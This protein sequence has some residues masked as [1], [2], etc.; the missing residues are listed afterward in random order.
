MKTQKDFQTLYLEYKF[1]ASAQSV[2]DAWISKFIAELWF[3]K[4]DTNKLYFTAEVKE[5]GNFSVVE[6]DGDKII[7]HWGKYLEIDRPR[8]LHFTL[9]V[10]AHFEGVSDVVVEIKA[11]PYGCKLFFTQKNIDTSKTKSAWEAMFKRLDEVLKKVVG[12]I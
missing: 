3:F 8:I 2:Y 7:D 9:E 12:S 10:P 5:N 6:Y 4:N 11:A 1:E